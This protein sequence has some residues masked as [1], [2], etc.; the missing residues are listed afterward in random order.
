MIL[1]NVRFLVK[2]EHAGTFLEQTQWFADACNEE[3]GCLFFKFYSD[4]QDPHRFFLAEAFADGEDVA[5]VESD[6][7][8][9]ACEEIPKLL[10]E[11]PDIINTKIPGKAEWDKLGEMEV[12]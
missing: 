10:Q 3:P 7:F 1:I 8:K 11:T 6:H 4:P 9:R 12:K 2:P 5:H